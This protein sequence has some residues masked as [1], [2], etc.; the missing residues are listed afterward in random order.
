MIAS[1]ES[2]FETY[3]EWLDVILKVESG[4][5]EYAKQ[6]EENEEIDSEYIQY[7]LLN[8]LNPQ[9]GLALMMDTLCNVEDLINEEDLESYIQ[10]FLDAGAKLAPLTPVLFQLPEE[11]PENF[12]QDCYK[13]AVRSSI[14]SIFWDVLDKKYIRSITNWKK[15]VPCDWEDIEEVEYP[16]SYYQYYKHSIEQLQ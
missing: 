5:P 2:H 6:V 14:A 9:K 16:L 15:V 3:E 8:G 7:F 4:N 1:F 13:I 12:E 11:D 10:P